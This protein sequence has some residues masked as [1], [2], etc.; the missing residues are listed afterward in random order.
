M[1]IAK[2]STHIIFMPFGSFCDYFNNSAAAVNESDT[3]M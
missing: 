3:Y 1:K 2:F